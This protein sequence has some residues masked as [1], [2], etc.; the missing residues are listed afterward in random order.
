MSWLQIRFAAERDLVH[1]LVDA[2]EACGAVA[3]SVEGADDETWL[4]TEWQQLPAWQRSRVTGLFPEYA[5]SAAVLKRI[6]EQLG[7]AGFPEAETDVLGDQDWACA[8]MAHY[9]PLRVGGGLWVC[10]SW[11]TPP[12]PEATNVILDPGLAFGTGEHPTTALCLQW[13]L[14][15]DLGGKTVIDFGCGSGILSLAALKLGAREAM[16]VDVDPQALTASRENAARN[17]LEQ[18]FR[19]VAP[20]TL[21]ADAEADIVVANILAEP[22]IRLAPRIATL[23]K[24]AGRLALSGMLREQMDSVR[25]LYERQFELE[26]RQQGE[27]VLLAGAW[28]V[29]TRP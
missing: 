24:P 29:D 5:D 12:D 15:Q 27:W 10:P 13:L 23:V 8:W 20:D 9:K 25:R 11:L 19:A 7:G 22:L 28:R 4:E 26:A 18:R 17:G 6:R 16:G 14:E 2:L 21:Q 1:R 3:V